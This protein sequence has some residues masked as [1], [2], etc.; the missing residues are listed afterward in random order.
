MSRPQLGDTVTGAS[1]TNLGSNSSNGICLYDLYMLPTEGSGHPEQADPRSGQGS[2]AV[3]VG[4]N[5][6]AVLE[7]TGTISIKNLQNER[8]KKVEMPGVDHIFSAGH[9]NVL[10]RDPNG[11]SLC[12]ITNKRILATMKN[13]KFIRHAVWS[14]D[15]QYVALFSKL[16][17]YLCDRQLDV[18]A[19]IHETVRIKS[20]AWEEH[21][22]FIYTTSNHIKYTLING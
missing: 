5:K 16:Y 22:A 20:G 11:I 7:A 12:D 3:W 8:I 21:S 9:G 14:P 15:G 17:L 13:A 18:K 4:R 10:I 1:T 6:F 19:T 2:A